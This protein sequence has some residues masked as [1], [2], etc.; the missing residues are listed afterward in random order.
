MYGADSRTEPQ[1]YS[2]Y[3]FLQRNQAIIAAETVRE[4]TGRAVEVQIAQQ[5][6]KASTRK[7]R[8]GEHVML[9]SPP[10]A[11]DKLH[12]EPWTGPH[13]VV[14]V[15][16]DHTVKIRIFR[17]PDLG[18]PGRA[19]RIELKKRRGRKPLDLQLVNVGRL[20]PVFK[21]GRGAVLTIQDASGPSNL[22]ESRHDKFLGYWS[23]ID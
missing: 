22:L 2:S 12:S 20:K 5:G 1:C 3:A 23:R 16:N 14:E 8:V 4:V 13:Q 9:Y 18:A 11:R 19:R 17:E 10:N 21:A 6:K 15:M 7:Y